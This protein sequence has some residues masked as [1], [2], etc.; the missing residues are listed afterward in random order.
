MYRLPLVEV[1]RNNVTFVQILEHL[2]KLHDVLVVCVFLL[3]LRVS[4]GHLVLWVI[5]GLQADQAMRVS[6]DQKVKKV[7]RARP[8]LLVQRETW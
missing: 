6:M 2:V 1:L 4:Q 8:A 5:G 3:F 7:T